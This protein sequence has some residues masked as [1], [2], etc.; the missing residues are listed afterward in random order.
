MP[1]VEPG[2]VPKYMC[3]HTPV[4]KKLLAAWPFGGDQSPCGL[5]AQVNARMICPDPKQAAKKGCPGTQTKEGQGRNAQ[6]APPCLLDP[7]EEPPER[8]P[9]RLLGGGED[10]QRAG[11]YA[12]NVRGVLRGGRR[13]AVKGRRARDAGAEEFRRMEGADVEG[14]GGGFRKAGEVKLE[15]DGAGGQAVWG[16]G[17]DASESVGIGV[18]NNAGMMVISLR[19]WRSVGRVC[20][21]GRSSARG[22]RRGG[23][24]W[25]RR[26]GGSCRR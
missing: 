2:S 25:G 6:R 23:R 14:H 7:A 18:A 16:E 13:R 17:A 9:R 19:S 20:G 8:I 22:G 5:R 24:R 15:V 1:G 3:P 10:A 12:H 26:R 11:A 4:K 21:R